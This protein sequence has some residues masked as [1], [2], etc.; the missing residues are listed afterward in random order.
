MPLNLSPELQWLIGILVVLSASL[1]GAVWKITDRG[2]EQQRL[3]LMSAM[4]GLKEQVKAHIAA[5][6]EE[7]EDIRAA[8]Q[9]FREALASVSHRVSSIEQ[10]RET[11]ARK[12]DVHRLELQLTAAVTK[13]EALRHLID[14]NSATAARLEEWLRENHR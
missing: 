10:L 4:Q 14:I 6:D 9:E 1:V 8:Q 5:S 12:E 13:F 11:L 3:L 2:T 7:M